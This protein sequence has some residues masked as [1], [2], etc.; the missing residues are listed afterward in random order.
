MKGENVNCRMRTTRVDWQP[1]QLTHKKI[2]HKVLVIL[3]KVYIEVVAK[4]V[5]VNGLMTETVQ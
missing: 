2:Q 4:G 3:W 1:G 5:S